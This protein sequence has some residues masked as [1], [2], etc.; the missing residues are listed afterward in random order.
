MSREAFGDFVKQFADYFP[1]EEAAMSMWHKYRIRDTDAVVSHMKR[2]PQ[3]KIKFPLIK[4]TLAQTIGDV[5]DGQLCKDILALIDVYYP[6]IINEIAESDKQG[7]KKS[8][9]LLVRVIMKVISEV[10]A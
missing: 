9:D 3:W 2:T 1:S 7:D 4:P 10:R 8:G 6:M 5:S